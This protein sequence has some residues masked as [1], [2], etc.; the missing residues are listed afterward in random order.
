[1]KARHGFTLVELLVVIA[2]IGVLIA[3]LL[4]AVQ[5]AREAARRMQCTNNLKQVGLGVH[6]YHDTFGSFPSAYLVNSG[7]AWGTML[8]PFI[9]E[10]SLYDAMQPSQYSVKNIGDTGAP[11]LLTLT[12]TVVDT[13]RCPSDTA[14]DV[15]SRLTNHNGSQTVGTSNYLAVYGNGN[16][17]HKNTEFTGVMAQNSKIGF[18]DVTDGTS[19]TF[20]VGERTWE[21]TPSPPSPPEVQTHNA[22]VWATIWPTTNNNGGYRLDRHHVMFFTS[23]NVTPNGSLLLNGGHPACFSSLHP[24]GAQF[25]QC[26]GSVRFIS[27]NI[28]G[29]TWV[30]LGARNDGNVLGEY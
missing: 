26:D 13:Y 28:D 16:R 14:P 29:T 20:M 12:R 8:L 18:R 24:G 1:M 23:T 11:D 22:A 9:E 19:N 2:I 6:N 25:V 10:N 5:Q 27:E 30:N 4:P 3:L 17:D 7:W 21:S 15:N